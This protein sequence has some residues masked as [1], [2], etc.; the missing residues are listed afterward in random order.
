MHHHESHGTSVKILVLGDSGVGKS[1]LVHMLCHNE[2]LRALMPTVGCNIDV[3]LHSSTVP[4]AAASVSRSNIPSLVT[5]NNQSADLLSSS[6]AAEPVFIE[7]YDISGSPTVRHPK[8][9]SMFYTGSTYQ[10]LILVHDL[11][12]KRSYENLWKWI[13]D[14]ME[15]SQSRSTLVTGGYGGGQYAQPNI[16]LLV[17]GTKN[18]MAA[19][20]SQQKNGVTVCGADLVQKYGGEAISICAI[21][22]ADFAPN[23][24]TMIAFNMFFSRII[25]P[26]SDTPYSS[27]P[28][29]QS[30]TYPLATS[31]A[32]PTPMSFRPPPTPTPGLEHPRYQERTISTDSDSGA[33]SIPILDFAT[34]TGGASTSANPSRESVYDRHHHVPSRVGSPSPSSLGPG[35]VPSRPITP[36]GM[37]S[38]AALSTKSALRA[39]YERNR[40]VLNQYSNTGVPIYINSRSNTP[41]V[42]R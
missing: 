41:S 16:P 30:G 27:S 32:S 36:T 40:S 34:F 33:R 17:I 7:F 5:R 14:Y 12:N 4:T 9:R 29:N 22:P 10:G 28:L 3:R 26:S 25:H 13:S 21:S 6:S 24:S 23:S 15:S 11:C 37:S 31:T 39:Q 20:Y 19:D 18:D 1:S 8:S 42:S 2:P 38:G 35:Q